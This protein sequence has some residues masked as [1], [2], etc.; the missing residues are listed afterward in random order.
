MARSISILLISPP[1]MLC[2]PTNGKRM[3][4]PIR[5]FILFLTQRTSGVAWWIAENVENYILLNTRRKL[6]LC[7]ES[8]KWHQNLKRE[9]INVRAVW[10]IGTFTRIIKEERKKKFIFYAFFLM[11][12]IFFLF[13]F[14]PFFPSFTL[15]SVI[16]KRFHEW[17]RLIR[18]LGMG[19][20]LNK[21]FAIFFFSQ[22]ILKRKQLFK[23]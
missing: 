1:R 18:Q 23:E 21:L 6:L 20:W 14:E 16:F 10:I 2:A 13:L 19:G 7:N 8:L 15:I 12:F 22:F 4:T 11:S 9:K 5:N 17:E 3:S